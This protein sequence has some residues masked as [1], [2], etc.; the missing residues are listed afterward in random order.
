VV[1]RLVVDG[2]TSSRPPLS[3][4]VLK[5]SSSG[6]TRSTISLPLPMAKSSPPLREGAEGV[7]E[8]TYSSKLV[9]HPTI[10]VK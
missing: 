8:R 7:V 9:V 1:S 6:G 10:S 4:E 2:Y 3:E 5:A